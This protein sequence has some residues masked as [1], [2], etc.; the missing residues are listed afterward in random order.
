[1]PLHRFADNE[2]PVQWHCTLRTIIFRRAGLKLMHVG[3]IDPR[4]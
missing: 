2:R 3:P 4:L 1:M